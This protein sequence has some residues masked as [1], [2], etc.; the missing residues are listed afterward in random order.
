MVDLEKD[1]AYVQGNNSISFVEMVKLSLML[2]MCKKGL[3]PVLIK[4][5]F[6]TLKQTKHMKYS[7]SHPEMV[8]CTVI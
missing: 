7:H 8:C 5:F 3:L 4:M 1:F 2:S 6:A